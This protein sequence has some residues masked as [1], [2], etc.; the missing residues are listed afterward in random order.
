M[1]KIHHVVVSNEHFEETKKLE[2]FFV[3]NYWESI[4]GTSSIELW[5]QRGVGVVE[6]KKFHVLIHRGISKKSLYLGK[7]FIYMAIPTDFS[8]YKSGKPFIE[9]K[10]LPILASNIVS[11]PRVCNPMGCQIDLGFVSCDD[12]WWSKCQERILHTSK[13]EWCRQDKDCV[14]TP[15]VGSHV[16]LSVNNKLL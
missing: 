10:V 1:Y 16:I 2:T 12:C 4:I 6:T 5:V 7:I 15:N 9:P 3:W 8:L 13:W 11:S 14:F